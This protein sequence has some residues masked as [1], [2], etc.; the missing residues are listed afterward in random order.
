MFIIKY[1]QTGCST[2]TPCTIFLVIGSYYIASYYI[3]S[4]YIIIFENIKRRS[5]TDP[6]LQ[7]KFFG[8]YLIYSLK[9]NSNRAVSML[10]L[11]HLKCFKK[12]G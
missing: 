4:Y 8:Y 3:E 5:H 9:S 12:Q 2:I 6:L 7:G 11:F 10:L 1:S